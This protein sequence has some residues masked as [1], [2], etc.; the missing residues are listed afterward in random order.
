[1]CPSAGHCA[2]VAV[3]VRNIFGGDMVST[4]IDGKSHWYNRLPDGMYIDLTGDQFGRP[5]IQAAKYAPL[6]P[7]T[8]FRKESDVNEETRLRA[9]QL[10]KNLR[11][12]YLDDLNDRL[13]KKLPYVLFACLAVFLAWVVTR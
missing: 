10:S 3:L 6:Y 12:A 9:I 2:V 11:S 1:M 4:K 13:L 7:D 8:V 5:D